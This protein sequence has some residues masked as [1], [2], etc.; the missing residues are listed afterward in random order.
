MVY[1]HTQSCV[2]SWLRG[3]IFVRVLRVSSVMLGASPNQ[4]SIVRRAELIVEVEGF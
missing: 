1:G 3:I 4:P 2:D